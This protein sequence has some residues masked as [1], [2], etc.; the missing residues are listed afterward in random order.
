MLSRPGHPWRA[1]G[2]DQSRQSCDLGCCAHTLARQALAA[3]PL[4]APQRLRRSSAADVGTLRGPAC[5]NMASRRATSSSLPPASLPGC[6]AWM[7]ALPVGSLALRKGSLGLAASLSAAGVAALGAGVARGGK[8]ATGSAG[9]ETFS[10]KAAPGVAS[11]DE[12][13]KMRKGSTG[14]ALVAP[15]LVEADGP[16]GPAAGAGTRSGVVAAAVLVAGALR[17]T[18][19]C[20]ITITKPANRPS[21][22]VAI[23]AIRALASQPMGLV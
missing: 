6:E 2:L 9:V 14:R 20:W 5:A 10:I 18:L 16:A 21:P 12:P 17:V 22:P 19:P 1:M 11:G 4:K 15:A 23:S 7:T 8:L 3:S 13:F